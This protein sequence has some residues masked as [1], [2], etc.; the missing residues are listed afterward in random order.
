MA[1]VI[2]T[3]TQA[4]RGRRRI[5][6]MN[7]TDLDEE[8]SLRYRVV[9]VEPSSGKK[10]FYV[11]PVTGA[12][13]VVISFLHFHSVFNIFLCEGVGPSASGRAVL[14]DSSGNGRHWPK[15]P[16][17]AR[18]QHQ[19]RPQHQAAILQQTCLQSSG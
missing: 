14:A 5:A 19:P 1:F 9:E 7:A 3:P 11:N 17:P 15:E 8:D 4:G 12:L 10:T 2:M 6:M 13:E 16:D 18:G